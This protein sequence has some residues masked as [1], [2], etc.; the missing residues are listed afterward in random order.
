MSG[1]N[2][3]KMF[4]GA[5]SGHHNLWQ[6]VGNPAGIVSQT[7]SIDLVYPVPLEKY[8]VFYTIAMSETHPNSHRG[9]PPTITNH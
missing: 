6:S 5:S 1:D 8:L 2:G 7:H 3:S 4:R 9:Q